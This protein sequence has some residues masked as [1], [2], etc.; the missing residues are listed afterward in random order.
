MEDLEQQGVAGRGENQKTIP[1]V[2]AMKKRVNRFSS[3]KREKHTR[4]GT[5]YPSICKKH[6]RKIPISYG[7]FTCNQ[8]ILDNQ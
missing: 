7:I 8:I 5:Q 1:V 3:K 4:T 2:R 6:K